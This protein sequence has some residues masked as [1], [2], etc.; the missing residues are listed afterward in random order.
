MGWRWVRDI[1][2]GFGGDSAHPPGFGDA[3]KVFQN[4]AAGSG[5]DFMDKQ[6]T[7]L[8]VAEVAP[9][10]APTGVHRASALNDARGA[11]GISFDR[12]NPLIANAR[13]E[14]HLTAVG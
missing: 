6:L 14:G 10:W 3:A 2:I 5:G 8:G 9:I 1:L 13:S 12:D 11:I 7:M 4:R